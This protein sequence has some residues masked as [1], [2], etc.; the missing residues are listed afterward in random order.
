MTPPHQRAGISLAC[1]RGENGDV[2]TVVAK[3]ILASLVTEATI[4][5]QSGPFTLD[6][7]LRAWLT[8]DAD[9][10]ASLPEPPGSPQASPSQRRTYW[11]YEGCRA[12][13]EDA[14][15]AEVGDGKFAVASLTTLVAQKRHAEA[16]RT[17]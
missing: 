1:V 5:G 3:S 9:V 17:D 2:T 13:E 4:V 14:R 11:F 16:S 6:D 12:L 8:H 10:V 15:I 7:F